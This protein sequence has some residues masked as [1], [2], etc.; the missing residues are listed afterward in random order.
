MSKPKSPLP[1]LRRFALYETVANI[2]EPLLL[3]LSI[4]LVSSCKT[5]Q[6]LITDKCI[7]SNY[8]NNE[9]RNITNDKYV[10]IVNKDTISI[11]QI[12]YNCVFTEFLSKKVMFDKFGIWDEARYKE[13]ERHPI[14]VWRNVQLFSNDETKYMVATT[15]G[16]EE[17][18]KIYT[19][20]MV[21]DESGKDLLAINSNLK[22][23][24]A[25]YFTKLIRNNDENKN[26]FYSIYWKEVDPAFYNKYIL[27]N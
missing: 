24:I 22:N 4:V 13:N 10:A 12:K 23:Y 8:L 15:G 16:G 6:D 3:I 7:Y 25:K 5:N 26:E 14:L 11:T 18:Y 1:L 27:R 21:F 9:F 17:E 19:S 2:I 20:V